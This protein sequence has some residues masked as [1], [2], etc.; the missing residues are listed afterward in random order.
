M[1]ISLFILPLM[2]MYYSVYLL[3]N[4]MKIILNY[5]KTLFNFVKNQKKKMRRRI[6]K[7]LQLEVTT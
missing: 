6:K 7:R 5:L 1:T 4:Y 3:V 2:F